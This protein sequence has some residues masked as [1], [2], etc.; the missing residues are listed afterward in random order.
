MKQVSLKI[1]KGL[2]AVVLFSGASIAL[3]TAGVKTVTEAKA[4]VS[5]QQVKDYLV[6]NGY[7]VISLYP[8]RLNEN[9]SADTYKNGI[10][11]H[12]VVIVVGGQ[13]RDTEDTAM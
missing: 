2:F 3:N 6:A 9:W 1:V 12:T 13:I 5:E 4:T 8:Y 11:Y 7:T 10:H